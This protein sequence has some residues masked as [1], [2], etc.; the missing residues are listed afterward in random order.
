MGRR[1]GVLGRC[2]GT[3]MNSAAKLTQLLRRAESRFNA[4]AAVP[5]MSMVS[6]ATSAVINHACRYAVCSRSLLHGMSTACV[7]GS[8]DA[9]TFIAIV[10]CGVRI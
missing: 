6:G 10:T 9:Y 5:L 2:F 8:V 1:R 7:R 4:A 3:P